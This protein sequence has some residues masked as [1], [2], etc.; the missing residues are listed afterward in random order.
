[1]TCDSVAKLIPLYFYGELPSEE[2]DHVEQHLH[3]CAACTGEL[4][5]LGS[6]AAALSRCPVDVPAFLLD[7]CRADL[8]AA[9]RGGVPAPKPRVKGSWTL[10]LEAVGATIAGFSRL[11]VPVGAMALLAIGF[12]GARYSGAGRTWWRPA[13]DNAFA[14]VRSVQA[15]ASGRV[16]IAFDET[17]RRTVTGPTDSPD[18]QKL[19]LTAFHQNN[20]DVRVES[21]GL[22]QPATDTAEVRDALLNDLEHD[23]N[24]GVR[25]KILEKL[26]PLTA[27]PD[28]R[29]TLA[30]VLQT[31]GNAGVRMQVVDLLV[32][33]PDDAMVGVLQSVVQREDNSGVRKKLEQALKDMNASVGTF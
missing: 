31:D 27:D 21:V 1:M 25:L 22:L 28:V 19:L 18:I 4:D 11:R 14:T 13:D 17:H 24:V 32:A 5:R 30:R 3:E 16:Q 33:R 15:D 12:V 7:E 8:Q 26:K 23:S 2:E 10:F 20:Q 6:L 9:V 29:K